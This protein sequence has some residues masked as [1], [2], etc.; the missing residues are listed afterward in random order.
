MGAAADFAGVASAALAAGSVA[1][2]PFDS[3]LADMYL[4]KA[5]SAF[6][7]AEANPGLS[8]SPLYVWDGMTWEDDVFAAAA[9][10]YRATASDDYL[11]TAL[12]WDEEIGMTGW[13]LSFGQ[14][15]DY[16]RHTLVELGQTAPLANWQADV[17]AYMDRRVEE[18]DPEEGTFLQPGVSRAMKDNLMG[19]TYYDMWGTCRYGAAAGFSAAL[20][21][22]ATGDATYRDYALQQYDWVKGDNPHGRSFIVGMGSDPPLR[23]HHR[24]AFGHDD[25]V[26]FDDPSNPAIDDEIPFDFI[27]HGALAGGPSDEGYV[28]TINDYR[29]NEVALDYNAGLVGLA[30]YAVELAQ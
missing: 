4:A 22:Q 9:E 30:A 25:T 1:I 18:E 8:D 7:Y 16:A 15:S 13:V 19:L 21:H 6:A 29:G 3:E 5:E 2:R 28:D 20:L 10:L 23:P 27:L 12:S 24:N 14:V 26:G 11:Q 17:D